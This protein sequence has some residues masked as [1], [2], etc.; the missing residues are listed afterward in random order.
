MVFGLE[1]FH[2]LDFF[3]VAGSFGQR[4][5]VAVDIEPNWVLKTVEVPTCVLF[6]SPLVSW[7]HLLDGLIFFQ[8]DDHVTTIPVYEPGPELITQDVDVVLV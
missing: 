3:F 4:L 5:E 1:F 8:L 2:Q 6:T 7:K